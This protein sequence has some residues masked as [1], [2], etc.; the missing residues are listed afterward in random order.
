[1]DGMETAQFH[2]ALRS[3]QYKLKRLEIV[4]GIVAILVGGAMAAISPKI[5]AEQVEKEAAMPKPPPKR[6]PLAGLVSPFKPSGSGNAITAPTVPQERPKSREMKKA[7][8]TAKVVWWVGFLM[9]MLG[10]VIIGQKVLLAKP[11]I[12]KIL[13]EAPKDVVWMYKKVSTAKVSGV[14]VARFEFLVFGLTNKKRVEVKLP[15]EVVKAALESA[16]TLVPHATVGYTK[17]HE[18]M[19]K[20]SPAELARG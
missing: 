10:V 20:H 15:K 19:F 3:S 7:E 6:N 2:H 18:T 8:G 14:R 9:A 1:M 11:N 13:A 4:I 12:A 17:K 16:Q 5:V